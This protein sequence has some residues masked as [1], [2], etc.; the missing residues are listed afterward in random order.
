MAEIR[1]ESK[2]VAGGPAGHLYLVFV[3]D[4]GVEYVIRGGPALDFPPFGSIDVEVGIL[5]ANSEDA[6][7]IEN[8]A[9]FGSQVLDLAGRDANDVW[10][11]MLQAASLIGGG[12]IDYDVASQNSNSTISSVLLSVAINPNLVLPNTPGL[13]V[14]PGVTNFL[15]DE[16]VR[17]FLNEHTSENGDFLNEL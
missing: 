14:Y 12:T 4:A 11:S 6:R 5:L 13:F 17:T 15:L 16:Y 9:Q 3:S 8:R 2:P 1:M 10:T 7:P